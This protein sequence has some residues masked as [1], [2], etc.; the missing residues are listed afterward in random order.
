VN[1]PDSLEAMSVLGHEL[2]RPLT[3]IRGAASLLLEP[4]DKLSP[5]RGRQMLQL[6]ENNAASMSELIEDVLLACQL[7]TGR[8][9]L[10]LA[11][12]SAR[13]LAESALAAVRPR[14]GKRRIQLEVPSGE[15]RVRADRER[16]VIVLRALLDNA[17]RVSPAD[18]AVELAVHEEAGLVRIEVRDRGPGLPAAEAEGAFERFRRLGDDGSRGAGLGL[19]LARELARCMDGEVGVEARPDGGSLFWFS[20]NRDG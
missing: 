13:G 4:G 12:V 6:I 1:P 9:E 2:R 11:P 3:V 16:A 15:P 10:E 17:I 18:E 20:L 5:E 7:D 19:Y 8:L 14:A